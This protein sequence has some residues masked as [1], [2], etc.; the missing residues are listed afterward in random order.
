MPAAIRAAVLWLPLSVLVPC[1]YFLPRTPVIFMP[2][3]ASD[4]SES[5]IEMRNEAYW[6]CVILILYHHHMPTRDLGVS[7]HTRAGD[8]LA[9]PWS[10]HSCPHF[11]IIAALSPK[12]RMDNF[13]D[14][15]IF[16]ISQSIQL[17]LNWSGKT[18]K[19]GSK[20]ASNF[21]SGSTLI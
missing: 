12:L 18:K 11:N 8:S 10:H 19:E 3:R 14:V 1:P 17:T 15:H 7:V 13:W 20:R 21:Q 4:S 2:S 6:Y 16:F 5:K 9:F